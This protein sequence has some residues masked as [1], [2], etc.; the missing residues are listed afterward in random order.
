MRT[1]SRSR[2]YSLSRIT[3]LAAALASVLVAQQAFGAC[4]PNP[5]TVSPA[6]LNPTPVYCVTNTNA[7]GA[8]SLA[9]ALVD[10]HD[11]CQGTSPTIGFD[12]PGTGPFTFNLPSSGLSFNCGF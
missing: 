2:P 12:I 5:Q 3:P 9:Q 11:R 4:V 6:P 10:S 7:S 8:G 1:P